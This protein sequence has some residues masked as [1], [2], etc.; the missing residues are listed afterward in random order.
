MGD[1]IRPGGQGKR[2]AEALG[3]GVE[4]VKARYVDERGDANDKCRRQKQPYA[5]AMPPGPWQVDPDQRGAGE[6]TG[7]YEEG[8]TG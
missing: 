6:G 8:G 4:V 2:Q 7:A 5:G 3:V 1:E